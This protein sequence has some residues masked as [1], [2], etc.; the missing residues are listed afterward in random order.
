MR[1]GLSAQ[2]LLDASTARVNDVACPPTSNPDPIGHFLVLCRGKAGRRA[3]GA[4]G[5]QFC[6]FHRICKDKGDL[7]PPP[8]LFFSMC[9][10]STPCPYL[11]YP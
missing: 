3:R 4:R 10:P 9:V 6:T 11:W 1:M 5:P 7:Q 2:A 8:R